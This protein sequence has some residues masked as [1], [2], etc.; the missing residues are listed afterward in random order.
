[1][2]RN[3]YSVGQFFW[4]A[5]CRD[6]RRIEEIDESLEM[7]NEVLSKRGIEGK[8]RKVFIGG[9]DQTNGKMNINREKGPTRRTTH[10][11]KSAT[12]STASKARVTSNAQ[13]RK[14]RAMA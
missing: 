7:E 6:V 2:C 13:E 8:A 14:G 3:T 12:S 9:G 4:S 5:Q 11:E 1:M 10:L